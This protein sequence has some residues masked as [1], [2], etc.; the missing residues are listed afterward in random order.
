MDCST[1]TVSSKDCRLASNTLDLARG[2]PTAETDAAG[3]LTSRTYDGL[4]RLT[5]VWLPDE[6]R[7][8]GAPANRTRARRSATPRTTR[9][10]GRLPPTTPTASA[11]ALQQAHI[12][13]TGVHP[14]HDR[15]RLRRAGPSRP[16]HRGTRRQEDLDDDHRPH[17]RQDHRPPPPEGRR[18][19]HHGH[20]RPWSDH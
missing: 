1:V 13:L 5:A 7:A 14:G 17:R 10:A 4:G 18:G 2:R 19:H 3:L 15:H 20:R 12:R 8:N 16:G 11:A 6:P 9:T